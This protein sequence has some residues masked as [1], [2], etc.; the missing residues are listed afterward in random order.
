MLFLHPHFHNKTYSR[1]SYNGFEGV[2]PSLG[3]TWLC[4]GLISGYEDANR[5]HPH[6]VMYVD[7]EQ[8]K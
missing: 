6:S 7:R 2:P 3:T 4:I 5:S 8:G 1:S